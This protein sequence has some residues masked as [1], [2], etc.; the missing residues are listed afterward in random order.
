MIEKWLVMQSLLGVKQV[1][2][3]WE[4]VTVKVVR[5]MMMSCLKR[6]EFFCVFTGGV[7]SI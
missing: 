1:P 6:I 2:E 7:F 3:D 4:R 5:W